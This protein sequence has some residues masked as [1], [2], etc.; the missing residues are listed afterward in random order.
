MRSIAFLLF[1]FSGIILSAQNLV[2][3]PGL[4][5]YDKKPVESYRPNGPNRPTGWLQ[6]YYGSTDFYYSKNPSEVT[7]KFYYIEP[8]EGNA[9]VG[10]C[11]SDQYREG[12]V[13]TLKSPL[14]E[15]ETYSFSMAIYVG[16]TASRQ[17]VGVYF[18]SNKDSLVQSVPFDLVPQL[19]W[20]YALDPDST[21]EWRILQ[22]DYIAR[23]GERF[24]IISDFLPHTVVDKSKNAVHHGPSNSSYYY[25]LDEINL[26]DP[27]F[28]EPPDTANELVENIPVAI[29]SVPD[30]AAGKTFVTQNILFETNKSNL[31]EESYPTLFQIIDALKAQPNL[32]VEIDGHTDNVGNV[33]A[34]QKLSEQRAKAVADFLIRNGIDADRITW[35]GF[36]SSKPI[37]D[38]ND[39]NRRVEFIFSE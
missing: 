20:D 26:L 3:N 23:G 6:P 35:K 29:D 31:K 2:V 39:K 37:G 14:K 5:E 9:H 28:Q 34:N 12:L 36:G 13:G 8:F 11:G 25:Y 24:F 15:G 33:S 32:K 30:I 21:G 18:S 10:M 19:I 27:N 38:D 17:S 4:E 16:N 7:Q 1:W 22:A